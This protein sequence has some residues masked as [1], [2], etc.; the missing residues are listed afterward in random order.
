MK[1]HKF[2]IIDVLVLIGLVLIAVVVWKRQ[3]IKNT[4]TGGNTKSVRFI[5]V[6]ENEHPTVLEQ[7]K[8][9]NR[10][11]AEYRFQEAE[12]KDIRIE[13]Q[14]STMP[15]EQGV[16]EVVELPDKFSAT[17]E[18]EGKVRF[19]GPYMQLGGQEVKAGIP[20]ILKTENFAV[21]SEIVFVEVLQ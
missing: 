18:V 5:C 16:L 9:G 10:L 2:N 6:V 20:Y 1:K 7:L 21:N 12:I 11:F 13:K 19:D 17:V 14:K 8:V 15:N 4:V 3:A